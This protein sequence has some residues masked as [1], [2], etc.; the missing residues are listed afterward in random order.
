MNKETFLQKLELSSISGAHKQEITLLIE[1][2]TWNVDTIEL[3]KDIIQ[4]DIESDEVLF[5]V[6]DQDAIKMAEEELV[7]GLDSVEQTLKEDMAY[8]E[9]EMNDI[10]NLAKELDKGIDQA[11]MDTLKEDIQSAV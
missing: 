9:T 11:E 1:N 2:N 4:K 7:K 6:E 3:I 5:T 10:E 8:V